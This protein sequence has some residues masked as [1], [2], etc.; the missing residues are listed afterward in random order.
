MSNERLPNAVEAP[1]TLAVQRGMR[2]WVNDSEQHPE[3]VSGQRCKVPGGEEIGGW[4]TRTWSKW[5]T[6]GE[7]AITNG[8]FSSW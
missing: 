2:V 1:G 4:D 6:M 8:L 3:W 7:L 5:L